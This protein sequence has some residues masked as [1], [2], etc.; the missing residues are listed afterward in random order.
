VKPLNQGLRTGID[1]WVEALMRMPVAGQKAFETKNI[2][3]IGAAD[4]YWA[5]GAGLE[6]AN[7]A[8]NQG[9]HDVLAELGLFD[10]QIAQPPRRDDER[11]DR[12]SGDSVNQRRAAG[13]LRQLTHERSRTM[14]N[15]QLR[16]S[17]PAALR[18]IDPAFLNDERAW[19][20]LAGC[21]HTL[22]AT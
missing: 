21:G 19:R 18:D 22:P 4:D 10:H 11:L 6:Q 17:F 2:A 1:L 12:L 3:I 14:R 13:Q 16:M 20:D 9:T 7:P 8:Q 5:A 15:D